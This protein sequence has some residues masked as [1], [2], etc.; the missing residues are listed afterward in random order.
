MSL[1]IKIVTT[2]VPTTAPV[3]ASRDSGATWA[4]VPITTV[5]SQQVGYLTSVPA[6]TYAIGTVQF[7]AIG[8]SATM[9]SNPGVITVVAAATAPTLTSFTPSSGYRSDLITVTGTNLAGLTAVRVNGVNAPVFSVVSATQFTFYIPSTAT[10]GPISAVSPAGTATSP[11]NLAIIP[12][13]PTPKPWRTKHSGNSFAAIEPGAHTFLNTKAQAKLVALGSNAQ[14]LEPQEFGHGGDTIADYA[15]YIPVIRASYNA[16]EENILFVYC[17]PFN[18]K[19]NYPTRTPQQAADGLNANAQAVKADGLD[20]KII[21]MAGA[22][23]T[24]SGPTAPTPDWDQFIADTRVILRQM[25]ANGTAHFDWVVDP[26]PIYQ[27]SDSGMGDRLHPNRYALELAFMPPLMH[28]AFKVMLGIPEP[29]P[30]PVP[31]Y[32]GPNQLAGYTL[33]TWPVHSPEFV[34]TSGIVTNSAGVGSLAAVGRANK[35]LPAG[36]A[37]RVLTR[38]PVDNSVMGFIYAQEGDTLQNYTGGKAGIYRGDGGGRLLGMLN[39]GSPAGDKLTVD[40]GDYGIFGR[41][42]NPSTG[43]ATWYMEKTRDGGF[44]SYGRLALD[45]TGAGEIFLGLTQYQNGVSHTDFV[46]VSGGWIDA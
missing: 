5:A 31:N 6:A 4:T 24:S 2:L 12:T 16:A 23:N 8:Y 15:N 14:M 45:Y 19:I 11:A 25:I 35:K 41:D 42:I 32:T 37:G 22:P 44:S 3:E 26:Y 20:F 27:P 39:N 28:G 10:D 38:F 33:V 34:D 43:A 1:Q 9:V 36:V 46:Q 29:T 7:R 21:L 17:E 30:T 40:L 18:E 13:P